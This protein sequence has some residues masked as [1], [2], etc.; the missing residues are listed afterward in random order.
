MAKAADT[1]GG[2]G[3]GANA[4]A[5]AKAAAET[6]E[7]LKVEAE[8]LAAQKKATALVKLRVCCAS[9]G[10]DENVYAR[11]DVFETTAE[12]AKALGDMVEKA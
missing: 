6:A 5:E 9:L 4:A 2:G 7:G 8:K 10:E 1:G 11:G 12:R 3:G